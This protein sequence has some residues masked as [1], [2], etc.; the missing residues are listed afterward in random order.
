MSSSTT[1]AGTTSSTVAGLIATSTAVVGRVLCATGTNADGDDDGDLVQLATAEG[2]VGSVACFCTCC[3]SNPVDL[4]VVKLTAGEAEKAATEPGEALLRGTQRGRG[5]SIC[6]C[7]LRCC[8]CKQ[9]TQTW[10]AR[11]GKLYLIYSTAGAKM[12]ML[13]AAEPQLANWLQIYVCGDHLVQNCC[14]G[15]SSGDVLGTA[16]GTRGCRHAWETRLQAR[17]LTLTPPAVSTL[18]AGRT[19]ALRVRGTAAG[20]VLC[21]ALP[22]LSPAAWPLERRVC[23]TAAGWGLCWAGGGLTRPFLCIAATSMFCQG[24]SRAG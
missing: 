9:P 20:W 16:D 14:M 8:L 21:W 17:R 23:A 19:L 4:V 2:L 18:L 22:A 12:Y 13:A 10:S 1:R 5:V 24:P 6:S 7:R 3:S 11:Q 15:L